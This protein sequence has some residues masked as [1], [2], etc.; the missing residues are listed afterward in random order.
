[1]ASEAP[2]CLIIGGGITGLIAAVTLQQQGI[3]PLILDKGYGLGGRLASRRLQAPS[4]S[5]GQFDYGAQ[6]FTV[7]TP[8]FQ[9]WVDDWLRQGIVKVWSTGFA[10]IM[11]GVRSSDRPQVW[12]ATA[13]W[14]A[15]APL[16]SI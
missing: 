1:M 10:N 6:Q 12:P 16:P 3:Q 14:S 4:G 5:E 13:A 15:S 8:S 7:G 11:G 2:V 9:T